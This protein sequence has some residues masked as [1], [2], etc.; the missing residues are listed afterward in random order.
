M[1]LLFTS[2]LPS[3]HKF[4]LKKSTQNSNLGTDMGV[5]NFTFVQ[6]FLG[7]QSPNGASQYQI[8]ALLICF[9][10]TQSD[11]QHR[12]CEQTL[13]KWIKHTVYWQDLIIEGFDCS[14]E[15]FRV[16]TNFILSFFVSIARRTSMFL[17]SRCDDTYNAENQ[18][19]GIWKCIG[20]LRFMV[21]LSISQARNVMSTREKGNL[22]K[23][24]QEIPE[25]IFFPWRS[26]SKQI[27]PIL[28]FMAGFTTS[29]RWDF[30]VNIIVKKVKKFS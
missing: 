1:C 2:D 12:F 30:K 19:G 13:L 6:H 28:A 17:G 23:S 26:T 4:L 29:I 24:I 21:N 3:S 18:K 5:L 25:L 27:W 9:V 8:L 15:N 7:V 11:R 10:V 14:I 22:A 16:L 20:I